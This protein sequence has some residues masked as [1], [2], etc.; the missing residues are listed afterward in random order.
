MWLCVE[1]DAEKK[2][3]KKYIPMLR[4]IWMMVGNLGDI[5]PHIF[6]QFS[7]MS[8]NYFY[9]IFFIKK[10]Y[11]SVILTYKGS[12]DSQYKKEKNFKFCKA[13]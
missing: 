10:C 12:F 1:I 3:W 13:K 6:S 2:D 9:E 8:C 11:F 4:M 7:V 5:P